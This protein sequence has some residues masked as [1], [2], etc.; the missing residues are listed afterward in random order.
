MSKGSSYVCTE[1]SSWISLPSLSIIGK[2]EER[3]ANP[4]SFPSTSG[5]FE[6]QKAAKKTK[7]NISCRQGQRWQAKSRILFSA[8][9]FFKF[10]L[11][12]TDLEQSPYIQ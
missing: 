6:D 8:L 12:A 10:Y 4:L 2:D 11:C 7:T 3:L 1:H 9:S 5:I